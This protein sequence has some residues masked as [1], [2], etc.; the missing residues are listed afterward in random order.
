MDFILA[1]ANG[2]V[3]MPWWGYVLVTLA[4]THVTIAGVTIF[5]HRH[6]AHRALELHPV[7]SHFFHKPIADRFRLFGQPPAPRNHCPLER[8]TPRKLSGFFTHNQASPRRNET[9]QPVES[10]TDPGSLFK[11][12]LLSAIAGPF[13]CPPASAWNAGLL[14]SLYQ[15]MGGNEKIV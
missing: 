4:L 10:N 1:I 14:L 6:Q 3:P 12:G 15:R 8:D 2:L 5:L 13:E 7:V 11:P 9:A